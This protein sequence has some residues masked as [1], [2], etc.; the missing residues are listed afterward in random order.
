MIHFLEKIS[1]SSIS[2]SFIYSGSN[3]LQSGS[4]I[5]SGFGFL[6]VH[7]L[8]KFLAQATNGFYAVINENLDYTVIFQRSL[9]HFYNMLLP[10]S[11]VLFPNFYH[12]LDEANQNISTSNLDKN[13][14]EKT[15]PLEQN[16]ENENIEN[17]E[18]RD[19]FCQ[20]EKNLMRNYERINIKNQSKFGNTNK[21]LKQ[22]SM[23]NILSL[24]KDSNTEQ[25]RSLLQSNF[26]EKA[27]FKCVQKYELLQ[28]NITLNQIARIRCQEGFYLVKIE[29]KLVKPYNSNIKSSNSS[30]RNS[31]SKAKPL[32]VNTNEN[33]CSI[34]I[35]LYFKRYFTQTINYVYKISYLVACQ[36]SETP[37]GE[38]ELSEAN[39]PS[40]N[41]PKMADIILETID[42]N[43]NVN[44]SN[45]N[46]SQ[47]SNQ[48]SKSKLGSQQ[49]KNRFFVEIWLSWNFLHVKSKY[50]NLVLIEKVRR[51]LILIR[52]VDFD[53][54]FDITSFILNPPEILKLKEPL[55]KISL[56]K[57]TSENNLEN[58]S[59]TNYNRSKVGNVVFSIDNLNYELNMRNSKITTDHFIDFAQSWVYLS[60][61][62]YSKHVMDRHFGIHSLKLV[63]NYDRPMPDTSTVLIDMKNIM[64]L[65]GLEIISNGLHGA[66]NVYYD[67][68]N[69]LN[70]NSI[71][72]QEHIATLNN[73]GYAN[74]LNRNQSATNNNIFQ[75]KISLTKLC[76]MLI[77]WS[78]IM[79]VENCVYL[80]FLS[81]SSNYLKPSIKKSTQKSTGLLKN[82]IT[83]ITH[84][85]VC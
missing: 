80:K 20:K 45:N 44:L 42:M 30:V 74:A 23:H 81:S 78:D 49:E 75:C 84:M 69:S 47:L 13:N 9:L 28:K 67:N 7:F 63:L 54:S 8:M 34:L 24:K 62:K 85:C 48:T 72:T 14:S 79:L 43:S 15:T 59:N 3:N 40:Q 39:A 76:A 22:R 29:R 26:T 58:E 2:F 41:I 53:R 70:D 37:Q 19:S 50:Q 36:N 4:N 52:Q 38:Q 27:D 83:V 35:T 18:T 51:S 5:S 65:M 73:L 25:V 10:V 61:D 12:S 66:K 56:S 82:F 77:E 57:Q 16:N 6:A 17:E 33:N 11:R 71:L 68:F 1:R 21:I 31:P 55:F 64:V 32:N 60:F 46:A